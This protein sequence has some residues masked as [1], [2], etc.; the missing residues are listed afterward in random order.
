MPHPIVSQVVRDPAELGA[1]REVLTSELA[2]LHVVERALADILVM[3]GELVANV[4]THTRS[5]ARVTVS[6]E[7][8]CV[9]LVVSDDDERLPVLRDADPARVGGNGIRIVDAFSEDWGTTVHPG[10]GKEV[11]FTT[12]LR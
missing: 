4:L 12:T 2:S 3:S 7:G 6:A 8:D 9:T 5:E 10:K 1:L 11:W